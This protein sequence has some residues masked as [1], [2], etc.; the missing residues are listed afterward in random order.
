[1]SNSENVKKLNIDKI[2]ELAEKV[3]SSYF[4]P[5]VTAGVTVLSTTFGL[6]PLIIWY[7]CLSGA[8]IT[9][10]CKDVS[11]TIGLFVF[12][13]IIISM[14]HSLYSGLD[15]CDNTF[16]TS[17]I[18]IAQA[19]A[20]I[21]LFVASIV[22]RIVD[23]ILQH[24]FKI[25]PIFIGLCAYVVALLLSGTLSSNYY[26]MDTVYGLGIGAIILFVFVFISGNVVINESTF[27]RIAIIFIALC[28]ALAVQLSEAYITLD[29]IVDGVIN[30]GK[31]QFG[32]GT[33][34]QF[35]LLITM[36][37]PAWFYLSVKSKNGFL[38]LFGV[39]FN[40]AISVLSMS[41]QAIMISA[42]ITVLCF[43]WYL[44]TVPKNY[45]LYGSLIL[46][47]FALVALIIFVT[48]INTIITAFSPLSAGFDNGSG[49]LGIWQEGIKKFLH[50]PVFGNGFYDMSETE[51]SSPGYSG[52][53][54]G[55]TQVI[56]FMCHNTFIQLL[57]SCGI[58][59]LI[60]YVVHRG[61]TVLSLLKNPDDGRLFIFL[62]MCAIILTSLLDNHIFY[63]Q[64]LFIY[65]SLLAVFTVSEKR[66][67]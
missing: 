55:F 1:M 8:A 35:G 18:F 56:P 48:N 16:T 17:P 19:L 58:V 20:A 65:A 10:C 33:Y 49:R 64:P 53:G 52:E 51:N 24:R 9:L 62:T 38:Y 44:I 34:N 21:L 67:N 5:F 26:Y 23:S 42:V 43:I 54:Y 50:N 66:E 57:F 40:L 12:M 3:F 14:R 28:A 59:G 61:Q 45:K 41:R 25:T 13:H 47:A 11:P 2:R 30:R 37:I 4:F 7:I 31:I 22:Y 63:V 32:W 36:C 60:A 15:W 39:P 6:E 29:V 46:L 27:K